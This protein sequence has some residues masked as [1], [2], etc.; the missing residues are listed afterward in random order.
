MLIPLPN[1]VLYVAFDGGVC[2]TYDVK[3][4]FIHPT[5]SNT[6]NELETTKGLFDKVKIGMDGCSVVWNN[7]L[8]LYCE[9]LYKF[10]KNVD[11]II[12]PKTTRAKKR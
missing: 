11:R 6:F 12:K 3:P 8:D 9:E 4:L 5:L 2:K 1:F 7:R 10:G